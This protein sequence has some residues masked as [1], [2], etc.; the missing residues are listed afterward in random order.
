MESKES[1]RN[2]IMRQ[3]N[4]TLLSFLDYFIWKFICEEIDDINAEKLKIILKV[5]KERIN[6]IHSHPDL[7][8]YVNLKNLSHDLSLILEIIEK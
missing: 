7:K 3:N 8:L 2:L 1:Y 5:I 6:E 4:Q